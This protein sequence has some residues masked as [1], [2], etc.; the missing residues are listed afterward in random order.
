MN[1]ALFRSAYTPV[2]YEMRDCAVALM[3]ADARPL[4]QSTGVPLFLCN[5]EV[6]VQ[7][8]IDTFGKDWL[9]PGDIIAMNDP[10]IQGSHLHDV[11]V[12]G[13]IFYHGDLVGFA[14]TRAHWLDVGGK[15][16]GSTM[17]SID[18]FQ[19]GMRISPTKVIKE[20]E[21]QPE[22]M[23][24]LRNNSRAGYELIGD[25]NAQV[26]ACRTGEERFCRMI[27]K[28]GY[29]VFEAAKQRIFEQADRLHRDAVSLI[30]DGVYEASGELDSDGVIEEPV[31]VRVR[32]TVAGDTMEVDL[33]GT[34][35]RRKGPINCGFAQTVSAVQY[36][37]KSLVLPEM[38]I[39][40]GSFS[41]LS[42]LIPDDCFLNAK[43]PDPCEWYFSGLGLLVSLIISALAPALG[44][45]AVAPDYG[46]SMVIGLSGERGSARKVWMVSEA[47][48]GGWGAHGRG[49][50]ESALINMNNGELKNIPVEVYESKYPVQITEFSIRTDSGGAGR[51]RGGCGVVRRYRLTEEADVSLW[52]ER[53][54]T[55]AWGLHGG[56]AGSPPSCT[57]ENETVM[58][59]GLKVNRMTLE[60]GTIV[61]VRTGGGGGYGNALER[62]AGDVARDV[63]QRLVSIESARSVYGV[64]IDPISGDVDDIET[65]KIRARR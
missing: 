64:V 15:D 53:S 2:I 14:A 26:T 36:A 17:Q 23:A 52:F 45:D 13:P 49:D 59:E 57:A 27:D 39:T 6:C 30:P 24:F 3:D 50:G 44:D 62:P 38:A 5:L 34:A 46:D 10:Y 4:G 29:E 65:A 47:T 63:R 9:H 48:A 56:L 43:E 31:P 54:L 1:A 18:V 37:Y 19:E 33:E 51:F 41:P 40:H 7:H 61:T 58:W 12:F 22:W 25:F 8:V 28:F 21:P 55:P 16:P 35:G 11:T 42:V 32:I 60:T 20:Y